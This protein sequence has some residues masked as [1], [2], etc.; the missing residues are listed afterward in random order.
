MEKTS[1]SQRDLRETVG[2]YV[3]DASINGYQITRVDN[4]RVVAERRQECASCSSTWMQAA[5]VR[6]GEVTGG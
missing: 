6:L 5:K 1:V 2:P 4:G 3:V